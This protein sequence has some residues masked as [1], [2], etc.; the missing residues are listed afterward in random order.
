MRV[1]HFVPHTGKA[2][3]GYSY[4][5]PRLCRSL[6][7]AHHHVDLVS[8]RERIADLGLP[9]E[10]VCRAGG[11]AEITRRTIQLAAVADLLHSHSLWRLT[12]VLPAWAA[13]CFTKPYVVS[14]RGTLNPAA[15][16]HSRLT[17]QLFSVL[18]QRRTL[19]HAAMLHATSEGEYED[20][21]KA[22][23]KQPVAIIPNGVDIPELIEDHAVFE[24]RSLLYVGRI[25]PIKGLELL[26]HSWSRLAPKHP[27]WVL[28][29]VG[30]VD[31]Q[32]ARNMQ[33]KTL[34]EHVPRVK[35]LGELAGRALQKEY[36]RAEALVLPSISENFGMVVAEALAN[37][38]PVVTTKGTPWVGLRERHCGWWIDRT[39]EDL[40]EALDGLLSSGAVEL[41]EMGLTGREWMLESYS[42]ERVAAD[43]SDA[44][45]WVLGERERPFS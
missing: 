41:R 45:S 7:D 32:Y 8:M 6:A 12:N 4:A 5:V 19:R 31:S 15:L 25:H 24:H 13:Q 35:F 29:I 14:P 23:L 3:S 37:A 40:C 21:R 44:Y 39:E 34:T 27:S 9:S 38:R 26:L 18:G 20:I 10:Q 16:R 28:R 1:A 30:P 42:W 22:G 11:I 2:A 17:K 36:Q 33:N 43:M